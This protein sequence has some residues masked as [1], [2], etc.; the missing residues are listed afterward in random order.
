M[1][2]EASVGGSLSQSLRGFAVAN[3]PNVGNVEM[4]N[5]QSD[6]TSAQ[7]KPSDLGPASLSTHRLVYITHYLI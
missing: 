5:M 3:G 6:L 2:L 1:A 4:S 7:I